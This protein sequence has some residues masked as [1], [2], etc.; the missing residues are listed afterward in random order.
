[1]S[2]GPHCLG[3]T[4]SHSKSY[5]A[6]SCLVSGMCPTT[7]L[8]P[9]QCRSCW[10]LRPREEHAE[11]AAL[12]KLL[13]VAETTLARAVTLC[14]L[15]PILASFHLSSLYSDAGRQS[16]ASTL[17]WAAALPPAC[18]SRCLASPSS[19]LS[20]RG[21][22]MAEVKSMSELFVNVLGVHCCMCLYIN[23]WRFTKLALCPDE[24]NHFWDYHFVSQIRSL[25]ASESS[26]DLVFVTYTY[27]GSVCNVALFFL[28]K[29]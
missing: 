14:L 18:C 8:H 11:R 7:P 19:T 2:L 23:S 15:L 27:S 20:T 17:L 4:S 5:R 10:A 25:F 24:Y 9:A 13:H 3:H 22:A 12:T 28:V 1:M 26:S 29:R 21:R 16:Q 6:A